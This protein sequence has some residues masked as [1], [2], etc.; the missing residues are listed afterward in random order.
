VKKKIT[1]G[2]VGT[3]ILGGAAYIATQ[4]KRFRDL[5]KES[6]GSM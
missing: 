5:A 6:S 1:L 4:A 2:I 3:L